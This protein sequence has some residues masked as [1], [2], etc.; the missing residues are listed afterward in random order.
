MKKYIEALLQYGL[1]KKLVDLM[2]LVYTRNQLLDLMQI[3]G[4]DPAEVEPISASL[5]EI[6]KNLLDDAA[7]RG[8]IPENTVTYRD[9]FDTRIMGILTPP[10]SVVIRRFGELYREHP[11]K[12]TDF[13][14]DFSCN[15]R[16]DCR[17]R[18]QIPRLGGNHLFR[19]YAPCDLFSVRTC[20]R[21]SI[22]R[23][24]AFGNTQT[25]GETTLYC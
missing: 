3:E 25:R 18:R 12:A 6:L 2:D 13:F 9:L 10:P 1:D 5:E 17:N 23:T 21:S 14:Y 24:K 19:A 20:N 11:K 22:P 15:Y 16:I 7:E 4:Y 8:L